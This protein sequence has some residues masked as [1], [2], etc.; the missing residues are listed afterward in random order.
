MAE[1]VR[2]QKQDQSD[3]TSNDQLADLVLQE[4]FGRPFAGARSCAKRHPS[5]PDESGAI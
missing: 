5:M 3:F 2:P 1:R 4:A